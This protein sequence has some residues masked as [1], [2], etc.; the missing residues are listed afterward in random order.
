MER[1]DRLDQRELAQLWTLENAG[2]ADRRAQLEGERYLSLFLDVLGGKSYIFEHGSDA[3]NQEVD[4][5]DAEL[6]RY[7]R[8]DQ[9]RIAYGE[10]LRE[11]RMEGRL[12]DPDS[13][14]E[15]GDPRV[16]GPLTTETG[17]EN[18]RNT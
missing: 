14:E 12:V 11:A 9:A 10:M 7:E 5:G 17:A 3:A 6:Y 15:I 13:M 8:P 2:R 16:D 18:E 4:V 1:D